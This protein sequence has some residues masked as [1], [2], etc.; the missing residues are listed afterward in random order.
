MFTVHFN[1]PRLRADFARFATE[2]ETAK[3]VAYLKDVRFAGRPLN[4]R[5]RAGGATVYSFDRG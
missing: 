3:A 2:A 1:T 5:V 4:L